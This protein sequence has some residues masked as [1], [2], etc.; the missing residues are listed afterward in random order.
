MPVAAP[1]TLLLDF[2]AARTGGQLTRARAFLGRIR[3]H[4][5]DTRL[6][7]LHAD[8]ALNF[9]ANRSDLQVQEAHFPPPAVAL[10]RMAWQNLHVGSLLRDIGAGAYLTF[11][12]DLPLRFPSRIPAIVGVAN[13]AP[14]SAAA[15]EAEAHWR[16]RLRLDVLA[17]TIVSSA[18]R[19]SAVIA[20]SEACRRTLV[21]HGVADAR[22]E[23]IP[24]G[25][26]VTPGLAD[27]AA[28]A[29]LL[30]GYG[31]TRPYL[32]YVS[33]FYPYKN[34]LR[35]LEAWALLPA[36]L[37][38]AHQLVLVGLP[39]DGEYHRQVLARA[40]QPDLRG[41][42]VV[43]PGAGGSALATLY[44]N[45]RLFAFP[46]LVE[47][48]PNILLEA[49][50]HGAPVAASSL[51]PMPEFGGDAAR[52]FDAL[53]P[54]SIARTIVDMLEATA[55]EGAR[56]EQALRARAQAAHFTW[57]RFTARVVALYRSVL[58]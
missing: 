37:R 29:R 20:L 30:E 45:A 4:D 7:V 19:A 50:A 15:R 47:N 41:S 25:V 6:H 39:W 46:S 35:L 58:A 5:P 52:Y 48:S 33:H 21:D 55:S 22:I 24:N 26:D 51:E 10:R 36:G 11:S 9:L 3:D 43:V 17:R 31:I 27:A 2:L 34:F 38:A 44:E 42:V 28:R 1:R 54:H 16:G 12:H 40:D 57:D 13:L 8:G 56:A 32:L 49:L 18:R 23:V 53:D 14:F